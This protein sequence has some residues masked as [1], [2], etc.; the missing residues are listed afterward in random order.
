MEGTKNIK[1]NFSEAEV[2]E[3][4]GLYVDALA[5]YEKILA[6]NESL[7]SETVAKIN[8]HI[9]SLK[10]KIDDDSNENEFDQEA[11]AHK[12]AL[13]PDI[14]EIAPILDRASVFLEKGLYEEA[15]DEYAM[16][17][18]IGYSYAAVIQMV[19]D[20]LVTTCPYGKEGWEV[21]KVIDKFNLEKEELA[22]ITALFGME[23]AE[24]GRYPSA[25]GLLKKAKRLDPENENIVKMCKIIS[26]RLGSDPRTIHLTR[27]T[28]LTAE[29]LK[30]ALN[31][32]FKDGR[33]LLSVLSGKDFLDKKILLE[34]LADYHKCAT[35]AFDDTLTPPKKL[36][37][38]LEKE[39]L[40]AQ[41]WVVLEW[42]GDH[43]KVVLE[44][45]ENRYQCQQ[46]EK[47]LATGNI[48]F[49][50]GL[51]EDIELIIGHFFDENK[52]WAE[53]DSENDFMSL[54]D[55]VAMNIMEMLE[56]K[57]GSSVEKEISI[58]PQLI[59]AEIRLNGD[60]R[61][62]DVLPVRLK[63]NT[64]HAM[65]LMISS[66]AYSRLNNVKE[67]DQ[68]SNIIFYTGW[69]MLRT[70]SVVREVSRIS[71]GRDKGQYLLRIEARDII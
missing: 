45:P 63:D 29:Q 44:N 64:S 41:G 62:Q 17:F 22:E 7:D 68:L 15:A 11:S 67:G 56:H 33:S 51:Q 5:V 35:I 18:S 40:L 25:V 38:K 9:A 47:I 59:S 42:E 4:M 6:E 66:D 48:E 20:T 3:S 55:G 36:I 43:A 53:N 65:G 32:A 27:R 23:L 54:D 61:K 13:T 71:D 16:L 10:K 70:E 37:S 14:R 50:V 1:T 52:A 8:G 39:V 30:T 31:T 24:R 21:T 49:S 46:V 69:A 12:K 2:Y 19:L 57:N 60:K 34:A 28:Q 26:D 58:R